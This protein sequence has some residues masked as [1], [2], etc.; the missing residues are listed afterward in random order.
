M[1]VLLE[2]TFTVTQFAGAEADAKVCVELVSQMIGRVL[3]KP[4]EIA[5]RSNVVRLDG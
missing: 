5:K 1:K 2:L 3:S 4:L